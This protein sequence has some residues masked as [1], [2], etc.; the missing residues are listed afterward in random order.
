M[1]LRRV[2][3]TI[4]SVALSAVLIFLIIRIGKID[5]RSTWHQIEGTHR[6]IFIKL[7]LLNVLLVYLSTE[8][9]RSVD[10]ALRHAS[11]SVPSR[12]TSFGVTSAGMA[13]G[14][15]LPVQLGMSVAR[16]LGTH[17]YGS[18]LKRG[19]AGTLLEQSFDLL[20]VVFLTVASGATWLAG[21]GGVMWASS[22][23]AMI[24]LALLAVGPL[25]RLIRWLSSCL[26]NAVARQNRRW[27]ALRS[28]SELLHS[29]ILSA[30]LARRLVVLSAARFIVVVLM[31]GET[32]QAIG[33]PIPLWNM[34]AAIPFVFLA[35]LV[36]VTPGGLGVNELAS[37]SALKIF[38]IPF[39]VGAQWALAN[40][41]LGVASCFLVAAL[42]ATLLG[43]RRFTTV[44]AAHKLPPVRT[45][46]L[47]ITDTV[48]EHQTEESGRSR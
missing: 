11:D 6:T 28:L 38:G 4:S 19:T 23:V 8:K 43:I 18:P 34:A 37:A 45:A 2:L 36:G 25:I 44:G 30:G 17:F 5:L 10:A 20:I 46:L 27:G 21:G 42:A 39:S 26:A 24:A 35:C 47:G 15:V 31:A 16:T 14:L 40:R 7:V 22:A 3:L 1:S 29:G 32:A 48:R 13:L 9:W 41:V 33:A 12:T